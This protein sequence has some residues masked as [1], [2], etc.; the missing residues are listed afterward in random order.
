METPPTLAER[1]SAGLLHLATIPAPIVAPVVALAL[2]R[3]SRYLSAHALQSLYGTLALNLMLGAALL[4]SFGYT[5]SRLWHHYQTDWR[6]FSLVEFLVRFAIGWAIL[7]LLAAVN[8]IL[9]V[10]DALR[11]YRGDWPKERRVLK[12]LASRWTAK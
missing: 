1:R 3:R 12:Q 7:A 11:A 5:L 10:R 6:E 2:S 8:A 9:A 4:V